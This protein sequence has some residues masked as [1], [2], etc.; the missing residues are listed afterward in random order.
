MKGALFCPHHPT[1]RAHAKGVCRNCY[2][3]ELKQVNPEYRAR[4]LSNTTLWK[5]KNPDKYAALVAKRK[6]KQANDPNNY[7][8]QRARALKYTYGITLQ[9][10]ENMA[11]KQ[12]NACAICL[13]APGKRPLHVDHCHDTGRIRG[14][15]CHQCN[16]YVG[17]LDAD[18]T[19]E[20]L[21]R[22]FM[23]GVAK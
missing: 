10:Y 18:K 12:N 16:W 14:L 6:I 9:D 5:Q 19:H 11:K 4:Q 15:L 22:L 17:V 23:Y 3:K 7:L 21:I 20:T 8:K 13:A 2:D 1:K